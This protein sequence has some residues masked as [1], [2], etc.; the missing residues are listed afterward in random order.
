MECCDCDKFEIFN[1]SNCVHPL[2]FK[3]LGV[4]VRVCCSLWVFL[5]ITSPVAALRPLR[6]RARSWGDEVCCFSLYAIIF[7]VNYGLI[8]WLT[9]FF[10]FDQ[11]TFAL[12]TLLLN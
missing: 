1:P 3:T 9:S 5:A 10:L 6:E 8:C 2:K 12:E 4:L 11:I 7:V